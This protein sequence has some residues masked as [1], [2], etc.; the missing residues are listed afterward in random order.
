MWWDFYLNC[1]DSVDQFDENWHLYNL[2]ISLFIYL[3][4][5]N[6]F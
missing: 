3:G 6:F 1:I 5:F 2:G 4:L